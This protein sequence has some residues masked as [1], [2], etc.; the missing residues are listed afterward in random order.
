MLSSTKVT[1]ILITQ[2]S[3]LDLVNIG[4]IPWISQCH[5]VMKDAFWRKKMTQASIVEDGTP[6]RRAAPF[7][8]ATKSFVLDHR[9]CIQWGSPDMDKAHTVEMQRWRNFLLIMQTVFSS[10]FDLAPIVR[11]IWCCYIQSFMR[12]IAVTYDWCFWLRD[13]HCHIGRPSSSWSS[14]CIKDIMIIFLVLL[15]SG[16]LHIVSKVLI[17]FEL[18]MVVTTWYAGDA[19]NI[20]FN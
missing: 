18:F 17:F 11:D 4:N 12:K 15:E 3:R 9:G 13:Q 14:V 16:F 20:V 6:Y 7:S 1:H 8:R 2:W 5:F 19:A 10:M